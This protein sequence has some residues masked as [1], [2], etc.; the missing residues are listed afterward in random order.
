[1]D[2]LPQTDG[3]NKVSN[4]TIARVFSSFYAQFYDRLRTFMVVHVFSSF[5]A[6]FYDCLRAFT[7][8]Q[9]CYDRFLIIVRGLSRL[10]GF[11]Y[12]VLSCLFS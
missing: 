10:R 4:C 7:I 3:T 5:C 1:M 8:V 12:C 9:F 2:A 6:Q 11:H